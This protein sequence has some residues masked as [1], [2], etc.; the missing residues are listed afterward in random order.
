[1]GQAEAQ[2]QAEEARKQQEKKKRDL[3]NKACT[4]LLNGQ[5]YAQELAAIYQKEQNDYVYYIA[6]FP[7]IDWLTEDER[8][9][10]QYSDFL[11]PFTES[12]K[13]KLIVIGR[14]R[15]ITMDD[16][17]RLDI[18]ESLTN[19][20]IMDF[21]N[22][23]LRGNRLGL[24][25]ADLDQ[26]FNSYAKA[27]RSQLLDF[28][29][30]AAAMAWV[31]S[32]NASGLSYSNVSES[33]FTRFN[34]NETNSKYNIEGKSSTQ[35]TI[36]NDVL[37]K[38]RVGSA[39]KLDEYHAFPDIVDNYAGLAT[40]TP[41]KNAT[42]YQIEGSLNGVQGRF[43]WIIDSTGKYAGQVSHRYFVPG[44]TLNGVPIKP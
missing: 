22:T 33:Q 8:K 39:L 5:R 16:I 30:M 25:E 41:I 7:S 35:V 42:L 3:Y 40:K 14:E 15:S 9:Q 37:G 43:E 1:L 10:Y 29:G 27:Q 28:F 32:Y 11:Q 19:Q 44:G 18:D 31:A 34:F 23:S 6:Q 17:R 21:F 12:Q 13:I 26:Q 2:R 4:D 36:N 24:S 38:P 20:G